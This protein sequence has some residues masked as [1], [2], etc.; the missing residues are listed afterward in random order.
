MNISI[1]PAEHIENVWP[2]IER[3]VAGAAEYTNGRYTTED[4][5]NEFKREAQILW[6]AFDERH[7]YG[8]VATAVTEYPQK[9]ALF[10]NFIGGEEG[11]LWKVPMLE[12]LKRFARDQNC[13]ILEAV[14]RPG[15]AKIFGADG[16]KTE[17]V[18]FYIPVE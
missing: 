16:L 13:S 5:K 15:W 2:S 8:F 4:I 6:I 3:Y 18:L 10:M 11:M 1:V 9:R 17:A 14:G 12:T 7:V